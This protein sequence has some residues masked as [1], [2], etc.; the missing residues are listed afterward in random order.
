MNSSRLRLR[1]LLLCLACVLLAACAGKSAG[2]QIADMP[3]WMGGEPE[4]VPPRRGTAEYEAWAAARAQEAG[5]PK[6][7]DSI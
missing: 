1:C 3:H 7:G 6:T 5:R 4:G 2:E